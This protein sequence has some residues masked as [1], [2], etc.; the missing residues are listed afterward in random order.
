M[1]IASLETIKSGGIKVILG[2][3]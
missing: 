2:W 3:A 1:T